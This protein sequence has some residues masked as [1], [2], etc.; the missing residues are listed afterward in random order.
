[1]SRL[2]HI[3]LKSYQCMNSWNVLQD[4]NVWSFT[5]ET[6]S[7]SVGVIKQVK[8]WKNTSHFLHWNSLQCDRWNAIFSK[9]IFAQRLTHP[10]LL[11]LIQQ[12]V[13]LVA[14]VQSHQNVL[15]PVPHTQGELVQLAVH[16]GLNVCIKT[17]TL[18]HESHA[19]GTKL[20][21]LWTNNYATWFQLSLTSAQ[22]F[23]SLVKFEACET[24]NSK[25]ILLQNIHVI[26][27][28]NIPKPQPESCF[29]LV[30]WTPPWSPF[31][32]CSPDSSA[33]TVSVCHVQFEQWKK[34]SL[35][36]WTDSPVAELQTWQPSRPSITLNRA[37]SSASSAY[38]TD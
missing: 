32:P 31:E 24:I 35:R 3:P 6:H 11:L 37:L 29:N 7:P 27:S 30:Y 20:P 17:N 21:T 19:L 15:Q 28:S 38:H 8:H 13:V 12:V 26:S 34:C 33:H 4:T 2:L 10:D 9:S 22:L 5:Y 36:V 23:L 18:S 14:L 1:M 25:Y 16:A